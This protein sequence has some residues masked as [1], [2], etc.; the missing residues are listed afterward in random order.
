MHLLHLANEGMLKVAT[1]ATILFMAV[2]AIVIPY[3]VFGRYILAKMSTWSGELSTYSLAWASMMGGAVGLKKGYQISMTSVVDAVPP[4]LAKVIRAAGYAC[5]L[6]FFGFMTGI[7]FY[8]T[9]YNINQTSPAMGIVLSIPY[10]C[11]PLG[12]FLMFT[13]TLEEYLVFLGLGPKGEKE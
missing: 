6:V 8:Q 3:E 7:G 9:I 11:L 13:V 1:W 12:F 10:A 2:I 5:T 4:A